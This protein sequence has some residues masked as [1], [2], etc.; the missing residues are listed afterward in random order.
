MKD[1]YKL[2]PQKRIL[3]Y[4]GM[5][6]TAGVWSEAHNYHEQLQSA[7]QY[8]LHGSGIVT[9][10]E[11][12]A[13]DPADSVVYIL[14]GAAVDSA[15]RM[16]VLSEPVAYDLGHN[17]E[18][19]LHILLVHREV[20]VQAGQDQENNAPAYMQDE[21]VI[22][23]RPDVLDMP[24]VELARINRQNVK[25]AIHD[26]EDFYDPQPNTIDLRFRERVCPPPVEQVLT[27]VCYLGDVPR[28]A[29]AKALIHLSKPLAD[30]THYRLIVE[31]RAAISQDIFNC[32]LVYLVVGKAASLK[33]EEHEIL[34]GY[35]ENGGKL[36]VEFNEPAADGEAAALLEP[37]GIKLE[38]ITPGHPVFS[39]PNLFVS[40]PQG[41]AAPKTIKL[42]LTAGSVLCTNASYGKVWSGQPGQ[43]ALTRG[44][45]RDAL[46]W[47]V[48]LI[49][50]L[51]SH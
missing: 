40:P 46:E 48:N 29:F 26:A 35:L 5:S 44:V 6:I 18:G 51:L 47:G 19:K 22:I 12:V 7:H 1:N 23:A 3:P 24:H 32:G 14:P 16:I 28:Q 45:V 33:K 30:Q 34:H 20:K 31:E 8:F 25:A 4:D 49:N 17:M 42:W 50:Y 37:A 39:T 15:G 36:L 2:F 9:G 13:S 27:G 11:V 38:E 10:L 21:F 43:P 41:G